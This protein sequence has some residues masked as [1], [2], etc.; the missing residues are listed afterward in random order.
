M[1][2]GTTAAATAA[3]LS[4]SVSAMVVEVESRKGSV[5][6]GSFAQLGVARVVGDGSKDEALGIFYSSGFSCS[7]GEL[8]NWWKLGPHRLFSP[9]MLPFHCHCRRLTIRLNSN[10]SKKKHSHCQCLALALRHA[11]EEPA[12]SIPE[13][14]GRPPLLPSPNTGDESLTITSSPSARTGLGGRCMPSHSLGRHTPPPKLTFSK[15]GLPRPQ[16]EHTMA[17][18][19]GRRSGSECS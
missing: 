6:S 18:K 7:C 14:A 17:S 15:N 16:R 11:P 3:V 12:V 8:E 13:E 9:V 2:A 19:C 4:A 5:Y 10:N 1:S